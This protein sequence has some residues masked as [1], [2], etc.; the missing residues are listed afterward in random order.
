MTPRTL[1]RKLQKKSKHRKYGRCGT[2]GVG[3]TVRKFDHMRIVVVKR[4]R[5]CGYLTELPWSGV[6]E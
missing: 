4:C 2:C 3:D 6:A 1:R 5:D